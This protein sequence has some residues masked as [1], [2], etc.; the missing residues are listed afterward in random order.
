ME[1]KSQDFSVSDVQKIANSPQG[2][3]LMALLQKNGGTQ[4]QEAMAKAT[5][6]NYKE[7]AALLQTLTKTPEIKELLRQMGNFHG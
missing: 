2:K 7:A 4:L 1:K 5:D 6:G 3:Q